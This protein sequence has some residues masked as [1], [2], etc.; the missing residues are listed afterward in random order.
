[1]R[2]KI[3]AF[4]ININL[5]TLIFTTLSSLM[6]KK[7]LKTDVSLLITFRC[8]ISDHLPIKSNFVVFDILMFV[9]NEYSYNRPLTVK[10][11]FRSLHLSPT[12][13][14]HHFR[15]LVNDNWVSLSKMPAPESDQRL[16]FIRPSPKLISSVSEVK[17]IINESLWNHLNK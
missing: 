8:A 9:L 17:R 16:R 7:Y 13:F 14:R 5:P 2:K 6:N 15:A 12:G 1:M 11:L 10:R 3:I 4:K